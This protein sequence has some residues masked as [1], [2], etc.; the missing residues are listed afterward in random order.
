M[1]YL[2]S[3]G[4][5]DAPSMTNNL[6]RRCLTDGLAENFSF[7]G[8]RLNKKAFQDLQLKTAITGMLFV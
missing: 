4:G 2:S 1:N 5:K 7:L 3:I 8:T 6:L